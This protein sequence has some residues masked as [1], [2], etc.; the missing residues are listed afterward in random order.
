VPNGSQGVGIVP[1]AYKV[2]AMLVEQKLSTLLSFDGSSV[3]FS[4]MSRYQVVPDPKEAEART[5]IIIVVA[6][7]GMAEQRSV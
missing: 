5:I 3:L 6:F 4:Q 1:V 2:Q 7:F